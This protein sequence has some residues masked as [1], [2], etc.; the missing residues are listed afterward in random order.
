MK[1]L[2]SI[3]LAM[4]IASLAYASQDKRPEPGAPE[5]K[6]A[7]DDRKPTLT[8]FAFF[9]APAIESTWIALDGLCDGRPMVCPTVYACSCDVGPGDGV[10]NPVRRLPPPPTNQPPE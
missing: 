2:L 5:A 3:L 1:R 9:F 10:D 6:P 8:I 7:Q 4:G